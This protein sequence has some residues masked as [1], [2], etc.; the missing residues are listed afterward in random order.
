ML[1]RAHGGRRLIVFDLRKHVPRH[2]VSR[3]LALTEALGKPCLPK[4]LSKRH[5]RPSRK[6]YLHYRTRFFRLL[7][8]KN[9]AISHFAHFFSKIHALS[10]KHSRMML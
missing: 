5:A 7:Q 9:R 10:C 1:E 6:Y 4:L 2:A 3:H 8:A